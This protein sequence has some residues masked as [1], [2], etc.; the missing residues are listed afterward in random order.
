MAVP[1]P[2]STSR[3]AGVHTNLI[4]PDTP[5]ARGNQGDR[6]ARTR[7]AILTAALSLYA[8]E[9]YGAVTMRAIANRLGFSAPAIYNYFLSKEEIF[10]T[11]QA[12][13]LDLMAE[14]VLTPETEDPLA[15]FRAIFT[16]YYGFCKTNPEYFSLLYVDPAAPHVM[17]DTPALVRMGDE[18]D[19]RFRRCI[20]SGAFADH[21]PAHVPGLF[22]ALVHGL[23]VLRRVSA[24]P[25][26]ADFDPQ[27]TV[28]LDLLV[29]GL[30]A[31][32]VPPHA[33]RP[34]DPTRP[35]LPGKPLRG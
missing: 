11:L 21:T 25:P 10:A 29:A 18:T 1:V 5:S 9:G 28:G 20:E 30:K 27:V 31:G 17:H 26:E 34:S 22:W 14:V 24:M 32:L 3:R 15:D 16:N 6:A 33:Y 7:E 23:A 19:R 12:I 35:W 13:G 2:E 4:V 8:A